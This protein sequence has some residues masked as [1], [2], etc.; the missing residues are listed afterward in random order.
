VAKRLTTPGHGRP[1]AH[2]AHEKMPIPAE[3]LDDV[4]VYAFRYALGRVT[5]APD[6]MAQ[7]LKAVWHDLPIETR[8]RIRQEIADAITDGRAGHDCDV[9]SW[10][11]VLAL[12][13]Q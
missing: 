12:P 11:E 8:L 5:H 1:S 9:A 10:R 3:H 13:L 6:T 7:V 4:I 2:I